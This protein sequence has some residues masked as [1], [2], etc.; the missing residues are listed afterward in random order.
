MR[1]LIAGNG[2]IGKALFEVLYP[3]YQTELIDPPKGLFPPPNQY[4]I[5]HVCFPYS[6]AFVAEVKK[7]QQEYQPKYTVIHSTVPVGTSRE[8][9]ALHSPV[10]GLH[11]FLKEGIK[12]FTKFIGGARGSEVADYFR[13]AGL[14][15]YLC[16]Q[17]E[18]TELAKVAQT[19]AYA[20]MVEYTKDVQRQCDKFG[21][22]FAEAWTLFTHNYNEGYSTLGYDE[23]KLP[24]LVPIMKPQGGHCT[25]PNLEFWRTRFTDFIK[26]MNQL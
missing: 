25:I 17:T 21:V 24:V 15:V 6:M 3:F 18:T 13:R 2:E 14:K 11:P 19:T 20:L 4:D 10:I 26:A 16:Q 22:P 12:T 7:L 1:S 23:F 5:L 8:C 9:D